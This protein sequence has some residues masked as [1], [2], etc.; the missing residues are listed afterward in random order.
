M[1]LTRAPGFRGNVTVTLEGFAPGNPRMI[2]R[3]IKV[4][5]LAM[6]GDNGFGL[7]TIQ[8]EP[9]ADLA[10]RMVVLKAEM[11]TPDDTTTQYSPAFPLTISN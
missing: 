6:N 10:S 5:P 8:P 3:Q 7:L 9:G 1:L 4:T 2:A 11:K